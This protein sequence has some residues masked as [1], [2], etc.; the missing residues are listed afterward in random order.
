MAL[1]PWPKRAAAISLRAEFFAPEI[2]TSPASGRSA[3]DDDFLF[4]HKI[5]SA[6][7]WRPRR[8]GGVYAS[9]YCRTNRS[10]IKETKAETRKPPLHTQQGFVAVDAARTLTGTLSFRSRT[11]P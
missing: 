10:S 2:C 5:T 1:S 11:W 4:C 8:I 3:F 6:I 7:V 9:Y